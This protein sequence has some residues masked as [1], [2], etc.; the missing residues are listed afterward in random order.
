MS[1][2]Q[3]LKNVIGYTGTDLDYIFVI[4]AIFIVIMFIQIVFS[5][6]TG[7]FGRRYR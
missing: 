1:I 3:E 6:V 2:I 4:L 5:I 7:M